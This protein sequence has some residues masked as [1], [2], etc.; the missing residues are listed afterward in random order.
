METFYKPSGS[1]MLVCRKSVGCFVKA[2]RVETDDE[3]EH[4][5][6]TARIRGRLAASGR[7]NSQLALGSEGC[8]E[9]RP[10]AALLVDHVSSQ[11]RSLLGLSG[12]DHLAGDPF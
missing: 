8:H 11:I 5:C 10:A 1:R 12:S 4:L 9:N 7:K 2:V 6:L 3:M